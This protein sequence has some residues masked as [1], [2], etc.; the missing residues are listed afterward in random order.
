MEVMGGI[1]IRG[2]GLSGV[3]SAGWDPTE[4]K[5]S[6]ANVSWVHPSTAHGTAGPLS[7]VGCGR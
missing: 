6:M 4:V 3:G 7:T 2:G 5:I 1:G